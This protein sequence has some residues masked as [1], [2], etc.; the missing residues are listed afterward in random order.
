MQ[1]GTV[2]L[3]LYYKP[4]VRSAI[5]I[6]ITPNY[7]VPIKVDIKLILMLPRGQLMTFKI[8]AFI[9]PYRRAAY[10]HTQPP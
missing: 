6:V 2:V 10:L 3:K 8:Q 9:A 4:I 7:Q 5:S 1:Y